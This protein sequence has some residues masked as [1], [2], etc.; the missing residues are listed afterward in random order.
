MHFVF[1]ETY[2]ILNLRIPF[3]KTDIAI[4]VCV[5]LLCVCILDIF[6]SSIFPV[7]QNIYGMTAI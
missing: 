2:S 3:K 4:P 5:C 1:Q 6:I 7:N